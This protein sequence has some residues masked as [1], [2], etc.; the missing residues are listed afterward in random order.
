MIKFIDFLQANIYRQDWNVMINNLLDLHKR[1]RWNS[2]IQLSKLYHDD[3]ERNEIIIEIINTYKL[4]YSMLK[5][6]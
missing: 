5:Q 6:F 2:I 4:T 1:G 3:I